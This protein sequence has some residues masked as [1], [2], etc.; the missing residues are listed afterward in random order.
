MSIPDRI[1]LQL[2][3][4]QD[5]PPKEWANEYGEVTWSANR[6]YKHDIEYVPA[7]ELRALRLALES[8]HFAY[9]TVW[10]TCGFSGSLQSIDEIIEMARKELESESTDA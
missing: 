2:Y 8:I 9:S 1:Y 5:P 3:G 6:V 7:S 10:K 4:D